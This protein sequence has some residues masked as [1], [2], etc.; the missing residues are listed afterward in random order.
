M[1]WNDIKGCL[2]SVLGFV[3][4]IAGLAILSFI[5]KSC[6]G[7]IAQL[8]PDD[9]EYALT[10]DDYYH[11]THCGCVNEDNFSDWIDIETAIDEGIKP[12]PYCKPKTVNQE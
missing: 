9:G 11:R 10:D 6:S 3:V 5:Y 1:N 2:L 8:F 4:V 7:A 12:C